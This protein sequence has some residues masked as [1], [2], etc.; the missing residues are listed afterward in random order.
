MK[1][2]TQSLRIFQY[3]LAFLFILVLGS[4]YKDKGNYAYNM[5]IEPKIIGLDTLYNAMVGDSLII[6]PTFENI[7]KEDIECTWEIAVPE[8]I[9]PTQYKYV[10]NSVRTIFGLQAKLYNARLT[11]LNKSNGI[12]YFHDFKIQGQTEF[13]KGSLVL[14]IE[15]GTTQLSFVKPNGEVQPRIYEAINLKPLPSIPL[16]IHYISNKFT[17]NTPLGYWIVCKNDG[18]RINVNNLKQEE[19]KS[20]TIKDNFFLPPASIDIGNLQKHE[21]GVLMGVINN[22]FYGGITTTW[23][24]ANTY[25]MFGNY[26]DGDYELSDKFVMLNINNQVS[27]VGFEKTRK[28]FLRFNVYG[29]PMYF[30]TQ[31]TVSSTATFDPTNLGLDLLHIVQINNTDIYA[32]A[33]DASGQIFEL[34]FNVNFNGPFTFTPLHKIAFTNQQILNAASKIVATRVGNIFIASGNKV[35]R[36]TP[37]NQNL[38]EIETKFTADITM[39]KLTEDEQSLVVG[40][41]TSIYYTNITTGSNGTLKEK[42]DGLPGTSIDMTWR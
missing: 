12:K 16:S 19:L 14:S 15:N 28:Q 36:Y 23:D 5:P 42:I 13:S 21:Q 34:K 35:Y 27:F 22:K 3:S 32:Y 7:A 41:G 31:Y 29:A 20:G 37:I 33:K 26:A 1:R 8:A 24:Q 10:G 40:A 17:G 9:D 39:L 4:C 11:L 38:T 25:G 2:K 6:N 30:G 18:V